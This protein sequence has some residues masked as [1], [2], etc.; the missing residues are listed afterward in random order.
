MGGWDEKACHSLYVLGGSVCWNIKWLDVVFSLTL[1]SWLCVF[2][3]Y[4]LEGVVHVGGSNFVVL[5]CHLWL[6]G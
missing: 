3:M 4:L 5:F 6:G 2:L 1:G